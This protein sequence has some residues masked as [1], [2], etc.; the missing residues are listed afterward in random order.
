M[1]IDAERWL[2]TR[3]IRRERVTG[4]DPEAVPGAVPGAAPGDVP[5]GA[6]P[7]GGAVPEPRPREVIGLARQAAQDAELVAPAG[8]GP[9]AI[10]GPVEDETT[11]ARADDVDAALAFVRRSTANAPQSEG[12]LRSKL[13]DRGHDEVTV[14]LALERA[15]GERLVDDDALL[16]ALIAERRMRG[17]ADARLRRDLRGRGFTGAQVDVALE[18]AQSNDPVAAAFAVAR[19]QA[20]RQRGVDP[21]VAV[22]RTVGALVRRGHGESLA[23]KAARDAVYADREAQEI[24]GR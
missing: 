9:A 15:R 2:A 3:G 21:E 22:R 6:L 20:A 24:A 11:T 4:P 12:R 14:D 23:R 13:R 17:H 8:S 5:G 1:P 16:A 10:D 7:A 19:E 18:R